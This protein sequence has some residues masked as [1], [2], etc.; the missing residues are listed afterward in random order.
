[1]KFNY[2]VPSF[3][4]LCEHLLRSKSVHV[5]MRAREAMPWQNMPTLP[6]PPSP[7][8]NSLS[9]TFGKDGFLR[10]EEYMYKNE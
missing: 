3:E 7:S 8:N 6:D 9:G 4:N 5:L 1:M 10:L 2:L